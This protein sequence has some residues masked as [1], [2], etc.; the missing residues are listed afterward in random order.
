MTSPTSVLSGPLWEEEGK[1]S[2]KK[3]VGNK[4]KQGEV[5]YTLARWAVNLALSFRVAEAKR[6]VRLGKVVLL[7]FVEG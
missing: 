2:G 7:L 3:L 4:M 1:T 5:L 6:E